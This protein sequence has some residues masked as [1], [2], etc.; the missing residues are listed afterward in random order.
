MARPTPTGCSA[1]YKAGRA[2]QGDYE[3]AERG[4]RAI[5]PTKENVDGG[6]AI[7]PLPLS[8]MTARNKLVEIERILGHYL[9][10]ILQAVLIHG[11]KLESL[12]PSQTRE[13]RVQIGRTFRMGLELLACHYG[14]SLKD[15]HQRKIEQQEMA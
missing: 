8:Q 11:A 6:L 5:D 4:A 13:D 7:D 1:Q 9:V 14:F 2:Y 12:A 3:R 15:Y 10:R